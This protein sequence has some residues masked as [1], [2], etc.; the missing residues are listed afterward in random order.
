MCDKGNCGIPN[1][2]LYRATFS[3]GYEFVLAV[4]LHQFIIPTTSGKNLKDFIKSLNQN[5]TN[6]IQFSSVNNTAETHNYT[7]KYFTPNNV[8]VDSLFVFLITA[9]TS[10]NIKPEIPTAVS[11]NKYI[12]KG[13]HCKKIEFNQVSAGTCKTRFL[14]IF[15]DIVSLILTIL[16]NLERF[17]FLLFEMK[18]YFV[19]LFY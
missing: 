19:D 12:V 5:E 7:S 15:S 8:V 2:C 4:D 1:E 9:N 13:M 11:E 10:L 14:F 18:M 6:I 16:A 17:P 3:N